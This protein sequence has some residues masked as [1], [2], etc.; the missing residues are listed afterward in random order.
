MA[1]EGLTEKVTF[2]LRPKGDKGMDLLSKQRLSQC[3]VRFW[4]KQ[5][6]E[7]RIFYLLIS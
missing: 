3:E 6:K 4:I 1:P 7:F 5:G 2:A